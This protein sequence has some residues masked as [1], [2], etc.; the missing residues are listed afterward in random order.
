METVRGMQSIRLFGRSEE[1]RSGWM[2]S[3]TDEFNA[4]LRIARLS[5][6]Y[7]TA[8]TL[9]F[10]GERVIVM[11][12]GT[13]G[14]SLPGGSVTH[15]TRGAPEIPAFADAVP[16]STTTPGLPGLMSKVDVRLH[17]D[18]TGFATSKSGRRVF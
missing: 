9:L 5:V 15:V 4:H 2:N 18:D 13:C 10:S 14:D 1:R 3:L 8:N 6:S 7:Q 16:R 17:P 11:A 12:T